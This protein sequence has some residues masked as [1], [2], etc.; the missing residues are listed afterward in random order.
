MS[1]NKT[2][3]T[4]LSVKEFIDAVEDTAKRKDCFEILQI[5][6]DITNQEP[7]MW[8]DSMVGFGSYHYKYESGREGDFFLTGFSPRKTALTIYIMSGFKPFENKLMNLGKYKT[9]SSCLYI[10]KLKDIDLDILK[11]MIRYSVDYISRRYS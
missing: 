1:E 9:G 2:K 4:K 6:K 7:V 8:G 3:P 11:E 5:M 10:K